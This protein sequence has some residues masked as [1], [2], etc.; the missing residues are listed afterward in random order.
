MAAYGVTAADVHQ[1][2]AADPERRGGHAQ[3]VLSPPGALSRAASPP[4]N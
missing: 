3:A 2:L 1:R 4:E